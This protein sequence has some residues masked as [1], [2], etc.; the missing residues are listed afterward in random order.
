MRQNR[1]AVCIG[2]RAG[3]CLNLLPYLFWLNSH[4]RRPVV[5][6]TKAFADVFKH[7]SYVDVDALP[8]AFEDVRRLESHARQNY[9]QIQLAFV[10]GWNFSLERKTD[11]FC[12]ESWYRAGGRVALD[13]FNISNGGRIYLDNLDRDYH[14][15][16]RQEYIG[17][18]DRPVV[19]LAFEGH[20][21]PLPEA[22]VW[23]HAL[24]QRLSPH[25]KVV[26]LSGV[27]LRN[28]CDLAALYE[29]ADLV[30]CTDSAPLHMCG[31]FPEL[32]YIAFQNDGWGGNGWYAG[33]CRG[34]CIRKI[35]Y[36]T[37]T[38]ER[39]DVVNFAEKF[40]LSLN[41]KKQAIATV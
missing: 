20:S 36:S 37:A 2:G 29:V 32:A 6:T 41:E 9:R 3:D 25:A 12:K 17:E 28:V 19:L 40:I 16:L 30:I 38:Q 33:W 4:G 8:C 26:S 1:L 31:A 15:S 23:H 27:R 34:T 7:A 18:K 39:D 24:T 5:V 11:S 13:L 22:D 10:Y 14:A 21:S 35:N